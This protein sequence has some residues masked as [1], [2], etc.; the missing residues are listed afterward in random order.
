[1]YDKNFYKPNDPWSVDYQLIDLVG[2]NKRLLELGCATGYMSEYF[3]R[4][5]GCHVTGI[6]RDAEAAERAS[7][8]CTKV[9][10]GDLEGDKICQ[11]LSGQEFDVILAASVIVALRDPERVMRK[12][13]TYLREGGYWVIAVPNIAH[14]S[15]RLMLF[16][17]KWKYQERGIMD[18]ICLRF[19]TK[20]SLI[21]LVKNLGLAPEVV[22]FS[23][24]EPRFGIGRF[25]FTIG[26][27]LRRIPFVGSALLGCYYRMFCRLLAYQF[28]VQ[29]RKGEV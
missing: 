15:T 4:E 23:P 8:R 17:G 19:F 14:W 1:M 16:R 10:V 25:S 6:E 5:C 13:T 21:N 29:C 22:R 27:I 12:L 11:E 7:K 9:I 28:I 24:V 18:K 2:R 20:E 3:E 26:G